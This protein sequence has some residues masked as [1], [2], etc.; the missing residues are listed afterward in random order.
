MGKVTV[1]NKTLVYPMP[2]FLIGANVNGKPSFMTAA[3]SGIAG[4][5]PPMIT[6][7]IRHTRHT[8]KGIKENM[9]FSVN[10]PSV[11]LVRETDYCGMESG[12]KAD[13][14]EI[15]QFKVFY[16]KLETAPLIEQCP[17]NLEC[18]TLHILDVGSHALV[19]G[20]IEE[21][22]VSEDCLTDGKPDVDK[23]KPLTYVTQPGRRYQALGEVVA[24]AYSIGREL[25]NTK[26]D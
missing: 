26:P 15:C 25:G 3:W 20:R 6:V 14:V 19:V 10:V 9:T 8:L 12:A 21:T 5:T 2:A 1:E 11:D 7:A 4:S 24:N 18:K 22:Y 23:V 13:K 16:G 17:V